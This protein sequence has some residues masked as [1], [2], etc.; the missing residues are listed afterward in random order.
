MDKEELEKQLQE[1]QA[2]LAELEKNPELDPEDEETKAAAPADDTT[3]PDDEIKADPEAQEKLKLDPEDE[4]DKEPA[5]DDTEEDAEAEDLKQKAIRAT[6]EAQKLNEDK[7][8]V[9]QAQHEANNLAEPTEEELRAKYPDWDLM[10]ASIKEIA[11]DNLHFK[12]KLEIID[13]ANEETRTTQE[14][15]D[16]VSEYIENPATLNHHPELE[17][18]EDAFKAYATDKTRRNINLTLV[19]SAF[20]HDYEQTKAPPKKGKMFET[21]TKGSNEKQ[22]IS[23]KISTDE[24]AILMKTDY[25]KYKEMLLAGKIEPPTV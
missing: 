7:K 22:K 15:S 12:K 23:D 18:K 6:T 17:G 20:L 11:K 14:W 8:K 5:T 13:Q 21:A 16:K 4:E 25:N 1:T 10:E 24:A 9:I 3:T 2:K 19:V